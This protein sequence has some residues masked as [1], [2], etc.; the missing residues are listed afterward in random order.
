MS[1]GADQGSVLTLAERSSTIF[2]GKKPFGLLRVLGGRNTNCW[3]NSTSD[4]GLQVSHIPSR[5]WA[6]MHT[7]P[8]D[9][10]STKTPIRGRYCLDDSCLKLEHVKDFSVLDVSLGW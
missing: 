2:P 3:N 6:E 9:Q 5:I 1:V 8:L 10:I 7:M 4:F